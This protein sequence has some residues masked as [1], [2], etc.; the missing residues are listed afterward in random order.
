MNYKIIFCSLRVLLA[1][2]FHASEEQRYDLKKRKHSDDYKERK[3]QCR[4]D[5]SGEAE[6]A[7]SCCSS[8]HDN[9]LTEKAWEYFGGFGNGFYRY[10]LKTHLVQ[11]LKE[12]AK[13]T[14]PWRSYRHL[15]NI[16][17]ANVPQK[18][19]PLFEYMQEQYALN[20]C[21]ALQC[22]YTA[23][24]VFEKLEIG[25][26]LELRKKIV[27]SIDPMVF[28]ADFIV[29][30]GVVCFAEESPPHLKHIYDTYEQL[31]EKR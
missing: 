27:L 22:R 28:K 11:S 8:R 30:F 26:P 13:V 1:L 17:L 18:M 24:M 7:M 29:M 31:V 14:I 19:Q 20:R 23:L 9:R 6:L 16:F 2:P 21:Q 10:P 3:K 12:M 15:K 5:V 25:L 4:Y